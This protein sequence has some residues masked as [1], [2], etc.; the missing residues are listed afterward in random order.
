[1]LFVGRA[2]DLTFVRSCGTQQ[3]F[4]VQTGDHVL[5]LAVAEITP[6]LGI[7]YLIARRQN[8]RSNVYFYLF[9]LLMKINGIIFTNT[10]TDG[11]FFLFKIKA[12]FMDIGDEGNRLGEV[13]MDSF[14]GR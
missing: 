4:K 12:V 7:K 5:N 1:M 9:G 3:P 14:V 13:D 10:F 11:T 6:N 2:Q 8:D